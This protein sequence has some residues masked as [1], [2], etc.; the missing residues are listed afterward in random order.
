MPKLTTR[1]FC[2][3]RLRE[4]RT[5]FEGYFGEHWIDKL[6]EITGIREASLWETLTARYDG[7]GRPSHSATIRL[8]HVSN[9]EKLAKGLGWRSGLSVKIAKNFNEISDAS[10]QDL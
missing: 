1:A 9:L 3:L 5:F 2:V 10:L 8:I 4:L 7:G 6:H